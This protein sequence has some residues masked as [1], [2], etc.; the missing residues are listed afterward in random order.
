M[1]RGNRTNL[2]DR[3]TDELI[4]IALTESDEDAAWEAVVTL[5]GRGTPDVLERAQALTCSEDPDERSLGA[6]ILGQLGINVESPDLAFPT[7]SVEILLEMLDQEEEPEVLESILVSFSHLQDPKIIVAVAHLAKHPDPDVRESLCLALTGYDEPVAIQMLI[8]LSN[9]KVAEVRNWATFGLGTQLESDTP[10]I[11]EALASR[12][13]D[14]EEEVR[15]EALVGLARRK[16]QRVVQALKQEFQAEDVHPLFVEAAE[17][18]ADSELYE[19]LLNLSDVNAGSKTLKQ[20]L[21][22]CKP[23]NGQS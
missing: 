15:G 13:Q 20:A 2:K 18:I 3:S 11:R 22:A 23:T 10:H 6:D 7:E 17:L 19:P 5:H 1:R 12:L 16:D 14:P 8:D 9:D 4:Q 21:I